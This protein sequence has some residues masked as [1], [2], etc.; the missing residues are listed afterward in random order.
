M[1]EIKHFNCKENQIIYFLLFFINLKIF[2]SLF[3]IFFVLFIF[4]SNL[5]SAV[6]KYKPID[7]SGNAPLF[8]TKK[9]ILKDL[10]DLKYILKENYI[11]YPVFT[12]LG[13]NLES[14][15]NLFE[16]KLLKN[17]TP[18]LTHHFQKEL[19]K[20]IEFTEDSNFRTDLFLKNRHYIQRIE[21]KVAFFSGIK[22]AKQNSRYRVKPDSGIKKH[23]I[24]YWFVSC[25][26]NKEFLFPILPD[27][28]SE[29][30]FMIGKHS[31]YQP[32]PLICEFENDSGHKHKVKL[33]LIIRRT[34]MSPHKIPIYEYD[35]SRIPYL[36]WHRDGGSEETEVKKFYKLARALRKSRTLIIDVRGNKYGSFY[37]IEKWLKEYTNN[38]WKN[39]IVKERQTIPIIR[40]LLNRV[41][42]NIIKSPK[43]PLI[44]EYQLEKKQ[45]QLY[46][47]IKHFRE[48][49]ISEKWIE[50]KFIFNGNS[51]APEWGTKLIVIANNQCGDGCQFLAALT[52]QIPNGIL[53]GTNTGPFPKNISGPVFQLYNSKIIISFSH[54]IHLNHLG[55]TVSPSGYLPNYWL[56]PPM[57]IREIQ[58]FAS[59]IK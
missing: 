11:L 24:N 42:W 25:S 59:K 2:R 44:G 4:Y 14:V 58:K 40:G 36:K 33:P 16:K 51:N 26:S 20:T 10:S 21:P 46:E 27:R 56:F 30:L 57:G 43:R 23:I 5:L 47:L 48:N 34:E 53:I 17:K 41:Q 1:R 52:K 9:Q 39:V 7:L 38:H 18:L 19:V 3:Y 15:L 37:F 13:M 6:E 28:H 45:S 12:K 22:L 35:G 54:R 31:N 29:N 55:E 50:T 8:L 32:D 49:E